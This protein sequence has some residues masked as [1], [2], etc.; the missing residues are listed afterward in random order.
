QQC[1]FGLTN[2]RRYFICLIN[3][4]RF[5]NGIPFARLQDRRQT[6]VV[7]ATGSIAH[8]CQEEG[9][10]QEKDHC[11][12]EEEVRRLKN[13]ASA[14]VFSSRRQAILCVFEVNPPGIKDLNERRRSSSVGPPPALLAD[15]PNTARGRA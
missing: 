2:V 15:E 4:D 5:R 1:C 14:G 13:P 3:A 6:F 8:G 9:C 7:D 10:C 11:Q 12:E